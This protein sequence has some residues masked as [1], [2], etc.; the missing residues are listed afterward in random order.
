MKNNSR[1][2]KY[3]IDVRTTLLQWFLQNLN[4]IDINFKTNAYIN[5]LKFALV[6][7]SIYCINLP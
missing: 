5:R 4:Y 7:T 3:R 1:E 6:Q 2:I